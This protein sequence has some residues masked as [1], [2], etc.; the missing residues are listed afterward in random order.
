M[1]KGEGELFFEGGEGENCVCGESNN[2]C[3]V[4]GGVK[5]K[6]GERPKNW[7][8]GED[9]YSIFSFIFFWGGAG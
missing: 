9:I 5:N 4:G 8:V 3:G 7:R 1:Q 2:F 6:N